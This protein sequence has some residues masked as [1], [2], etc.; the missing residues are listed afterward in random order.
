M[1]GRQLAIAQDA[2]LLFHPSGSIIQAFDLL[3]GQQRFSLKGH[4]DAI[5]ACAFNEATQELYTGSND[6]QIGVWSSV[7]T[8]SA[9]REED[10]WSS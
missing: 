6:R 8:E 1:Q 4:L 9:D 5:N 2:R 3:T 10:T 7:G